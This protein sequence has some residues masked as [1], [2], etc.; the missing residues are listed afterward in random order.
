[1]AAEASYCLLSHR[2]WQ[3]S[4]GL[5]SHC[6]LPHERFRVE[7]LADSPR[8]MTFDRLLKTA[9]GRGRRT[10]RAEMPW[11]SYTSCSHCDGPPISVRRFGRLGDPVGRCR[12]GKLLEAL[13]E[14]IC[15]ELPAGDLQH[16]RHIPLG[17]LGLFSGA[18]VGVAD[19]R[20]WNYFFLGVPEI[21]GR[22]AD[23]LLPSRK[24][25]AHG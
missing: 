17:A 2:C 13:P 1:L 23:S 16:V 19:T 20:G 25:P 5:N 18:A 6:R 15:S 12:C 3:S 24:D 8:Q 14:G 22:S 11:I 21:A 10:V 7:H 4:Y 9:P